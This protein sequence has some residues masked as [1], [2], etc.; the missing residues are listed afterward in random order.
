ML[1]GE[2]VGELGVEWG[3]QEDTGGG[4]FF[5]HGF[6]PR[7]T[8]SPEGCVS[9]DSGLVQAVKLPVV[10]KMVSVGVQEAREAGLK[11]TG[12]LSS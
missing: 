1:E 12:E 3:R 11:V 5:S 4:I 6:N 10:D 7:V 9:S 8:G 2:V